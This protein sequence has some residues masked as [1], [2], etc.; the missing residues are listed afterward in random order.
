[1]HGQ[2]RGRVAAQDTI[3]V[4]RGA[5]PQVIHL[6]AITD[7]QPALDEACAAGKP[8]LHFASAGRS[9]RL[10]L[11]NSTKSINV[12]QGQWLYTRPYWSTA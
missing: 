2:A 4:T 10:P 1:M 12:A 6:G 5:P 8:R 11:S 7:E 3:N 9:L